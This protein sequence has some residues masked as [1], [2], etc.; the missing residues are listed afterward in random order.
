[1]LAVYAL[2][3]HWPQEPAFPVLKNPP[4]NAG[5]TS[6]IPGLRSLVRSLENEMAPH[7]RDLAWRIPWT[8]EPGRLQFM[9][10]QRVGPT[11]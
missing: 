5:D 8:E 11:E 1:M 2:I 4:A 7:S 10:S 3:F 9:V 6:S